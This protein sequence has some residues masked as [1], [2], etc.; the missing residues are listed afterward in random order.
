MSSS[1]RSHAVREFRGGETAMVQQ[2]AL[3]LDVDAL[4]AV[5]SIP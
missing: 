1:R 2:P 5:T 4:Y 3:R